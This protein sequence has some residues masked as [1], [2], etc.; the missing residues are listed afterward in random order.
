MVTLYANNSNL[1]YFIHILLV[2]CIKIMVTLFDG[3]FLQKQSR[4]FD[5]KR[6]FQVIIKNIYK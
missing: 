5:T 6:L 2:W 4:L 1:Y 3:H